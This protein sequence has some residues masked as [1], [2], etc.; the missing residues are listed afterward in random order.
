MSN[1]SFNKKAIVCCLQAASSGFEKKNAKKI[2]S[3]GEERHIC[4]CVGLIVE[5][6]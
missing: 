3:I 1:T 5:P 4:C 2:R 6:K